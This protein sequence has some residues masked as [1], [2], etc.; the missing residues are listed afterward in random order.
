M[1]DIIVA[2]DY[3]AKPRYIGVVVAREHIIKSSIF[4][5]KA[6]WIKHIADLLEH[7]KTVYLHRF[8]DRLAKIKEFLEHIRWFNY[9]RSC[10]DFVNRLNPAIVIVDPKLDPYISYPRKIPRTHGYKKT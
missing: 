4:L 10:N 9:T 3:S 5:N 7:E 6:S 8:P 1:S 2:V